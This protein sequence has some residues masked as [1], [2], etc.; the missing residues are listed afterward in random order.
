MKL[1]TAQEL[2]AITSVKPKT[3]YMW[4]QTGQIPCVRLNGLVRFDIGD[5]EDW[6]KS[7]GNGYNKSN[8][9]RPSEPEGR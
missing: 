3:I 5:I 9:K 1:V 7:H 8:P 6:L 4:A 2:A